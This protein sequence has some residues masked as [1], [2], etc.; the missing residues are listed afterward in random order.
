MMLVIE[1]IS[2]NAHPEWFCPMLALYCRNKWWKDEMWS[3]MWRLPQSLWCQSQKNWNKSKNNK[4]QILRN[5]IFLISPCWVASGHLYRCVLPPSSCWCLLNGG[6]I[7][8]AL[9]LGFK[10]K[11]TPSMVWRLIIN[12]VTPCHWWQA[13]GLVLARWFIQSWANPGVILVHYSSSIDGQIYVWDYHL[14]CL[15]SLS[16]F[17]SKCMTSPLLESKSS[18]T[19]KANVG[20]TYPN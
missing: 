3:P 18:S 14:L 9:L 8:I 11:D 1:I 4:L 5:G 19:L 17:I 16:P 20:C 13:N 15:G 10:W 2:R 6:I 12:I 7:S